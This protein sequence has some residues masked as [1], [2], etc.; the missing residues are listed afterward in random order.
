M[1]HLDELNPAQ[2]AAVVLAFGREPARDAAAAD[3][4]RS[5]IGQDQDARAPGR[6]LILNGA[7]PRRIL[8]LTF[9]RRGLPR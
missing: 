5:R 6:P 1:L 2:H 8:L 7:D 9:A 4:R 3:H